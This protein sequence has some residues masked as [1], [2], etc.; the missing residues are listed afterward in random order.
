MSST[1]IMA[2]CLT[3]L[4]DGHMYLLLYMWTMPPI[5]RPLD[6]RRGGYAIFYFAK[7]SLP[8]P[9]PTF[10]KLICVWERNLLFYP[11]VPCHMGNDLKQSVHYDSLMLLK[12]TSDCH[13]DY[14][15]NAI[16][17]RFRGLNIQMVAKFQKAVLSYMMSKYNYRMKIH[18]C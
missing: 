10:N 1:T 18:I 8:F 11:L 5:V 15:P 12:N 2:T 3:K 6:S 17:E 14:H 4:H 7:C 16:Q 9:K 13:D